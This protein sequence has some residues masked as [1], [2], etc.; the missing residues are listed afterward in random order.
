[1]LHVRP[2]W[3]RLPDAAA[4]AA[5]RLSSNAAA[6]PARSSDAQAAALEDLWHVQTPEPQ[7]S[8]FFQ[9]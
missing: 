8:R 1:M 6:A 4:A 7:V 9:E 2:R 5:G 3:L